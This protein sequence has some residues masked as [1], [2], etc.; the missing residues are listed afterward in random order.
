MTFKTDDRVYETSTTT[1]TGEYTLDGAVVGFTTFAGMGANNLC[2]YF[3][4]DDTNWEVGIGTILTGPARLQRTTVL[5]SSNADAAVNWAAGTRKLRCGLPAKMAIPRTLSKSVAGSADVAL[6]QDEQ[7]RDQLVFTG[8]LTGNINVTVDATPWRW[9]IYN[10]TSGNYTLKVKTSGGTGVFIPQ[11]QRVVLECD[12]TNVICPERASLVLLQTQNAAGSASIDF[13]NGIDSTFDEY[14]VVLTNVIPATNT[15]Q[16]LT[17]VSQDGGG[18]WKSGATDYG[19]VNF[20]ESVASGLAAASAST[21][22]TSIASSSGG[23]SNTANSGGMSGEVRFFGPS[24]AASRKH[25]LS[26]FTVNRSDSASASDLRH[27]GGS[28]VFQLNTAAINGIRF[29]FATGNIT[30]GTFSLYGV[31]KS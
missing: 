4:T 2:P 7:R 12:G 17:R 14:L 26:K 23:P 1:G 18:T 21:G 20:Q 25:F 22:D 19:Y 11:G 3:A 24:S 15:D 28:G 6:T 29:L 10:N 16:F 31:R 30:S 13:V 27:Y 8:A 5:R 9:S